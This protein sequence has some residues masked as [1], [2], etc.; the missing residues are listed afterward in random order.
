MTIGGSGFTSATAVHFGS[1]AAASYS[2]VSDSEVTATSPAEAA[3]TVN[4]TVTTSNGTS[5]T[6]SADHFAFDAVPT[7]TAVSPS[8]GVSPGGTSVTVSGTGFVSGSTTVDFGSTAGTSVSV[9][10]STSLTVTSPGHVGGT[11]DVTATTPGGTSSTGSADHFTYDQYAYVANFTSGTVSVVDSSS[12]TVI[13]TI[14][15]PTTT[16]PPHPD[17]VAI[18][19]DGTTLYVADQANDDVLVYSTATDS[20]ESSYTLTTGISGPVKVAV[21]SVAGH[22][23]V[24]NAAADDVTIYSLSS[25]LPASSPSET[26]SSTTIADPGALA[27]VPG[28]STAFLASTGGNAVAK[29][30][31]SG[32]FAPV[33]AAT[34]QFDE[35]DAGGFSTDASTAYVA[36]ET[37][38]L[39]AISTSGSSV[40]TGSVSGT[41]S[42]SYRTSVPSAIWCNSSTRCIV[43]NAGDNEI[44]LFSPSTL[45]MAGEDSSSTD[46]DGPVALQSVPGTSTIYVVNDGNG[47]IG[48]WST[49]SSSMTGSVTVGTHPCSVAVRK[50]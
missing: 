20:E 7:V 42:G 40:I 9:G 21:N 19:P 12:E 29:L 43:A 46:I 38:Q 45:A 36:N 10:S 39:L 32:T 41:Q 16:D 13:A 14:T 22:L 37:G 30:G 8:S 23:E 1:T 47:T 17:S 15:L 34:G 27:F 50:D 28:A 4:V 48:L 3:G 11:V 44:G 6:S 5:S 25:D 33:P 35:P 18:S 26:V 2:V 24:A 31:T 49:S